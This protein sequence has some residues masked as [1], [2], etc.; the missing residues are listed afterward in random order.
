MC[1]AFVLCY[2]RP[3]YLL[4]VAAEADRGVHGVDHCTTCSG[5]VGVGHGAVHKEQVKHHLPV[6]AVAQQAALLEAL[7]RVVRASVQ[8]V[9]SGDVGVGQSRDVGER[10]SQSLLVTEENTSQVVCRRQT[11][12]LPVANSFQTS[13]L[14]RKALPAR[15]TAVMLQPEVHRVLVLVS[16]CLARMALEE[17]IEER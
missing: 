15:D 5:I 1:S 17:A 16:D 10:L 3:G 2:D 4:E 6:H 7:R 12:A 14:R 8:F 11:P 9:G 13:Q